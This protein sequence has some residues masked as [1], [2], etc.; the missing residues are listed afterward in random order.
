MASRGTQGYRALRSAEDSWLKL[1]NA[2]QAR[3]DHAKI[4]DYLLAA[5]HP[6]GR[7]KAEFFFQFGFRIELWHEF[8]EALRRHGAGHEVVRIVENAHGSRYIVDGMLESPDGRNPLV[9]T[10]WI[11]D[12]GGETPRLVTAYPIRS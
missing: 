5:S 12:A 11:L 10:V 2:Q 3:V 8:A 1:P 4:S 6:R 9:R 7:T